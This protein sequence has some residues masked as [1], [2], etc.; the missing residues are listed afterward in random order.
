MKAAAK[1]RPVQLED[2]SELEDEGVSQD[3][4]AE[5]ILAELDLTGTP[6]KNVNSKNDLQD[7]DEFE[8]EFDFGSDGNEEEEDSEEEEPRPRRIDFK[9]DLKKSKNGTRGDVLSYKTL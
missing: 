8:E 3:I 4:I 5:D 1:N 7:D 6:E 9:K 2:A